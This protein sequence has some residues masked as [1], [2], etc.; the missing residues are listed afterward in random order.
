MKKVCLLCV[1]V[2]QVRVITKRGSYVHRPPQHGSLNTAPSQPALDSKRRQRLSSS[3]SEEPDAPPSLPAAEPQTP[4]PLE[5]ARKRLK[6]LLSQLTPKKLK[7]PVQV[8][9]P[10]LPEKFSPRRTRNKS[11]ASPSTSFLV[12]NM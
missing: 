6:H 3:R 8:I 7:S 2:P 10:S 1:F 11:P 12:L 9:Q 5:I 4:L